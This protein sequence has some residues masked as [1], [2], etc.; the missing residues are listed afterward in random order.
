MLY[1]AFFPPTSDAMTTLFAPKRITIGPLKIRFNWLIAACIGL[2]VFSFIR[3]G[4]WQL[5][6]AEEK[7]QLQQ[8]VEAL[9]S[10]AAVEIEKLDYRALFDSGALNYFN[11]IATGNY[12]NERTVLVVAQF[13]NGQIG[14]EVITPFQLKSN[15]EIILVSRG[16][17][18]AIIPPN[19]PVNTRPVEGEISLSALVHVPKSIPPQREALG[20]QQWPLELRNLNVK[21]IES[22]L[23]EPVF[24]FVVRLNEN[25]PGV[26]ARH[27][28]AV[29]VRTGMNISYAIQWFSF[30]FVVILLSLVF[31]SN[32]VNLLKEKMNSIDESKQ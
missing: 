1:H 21:Q 8:E 25:A 4:N 2:T 11:I 14:Y 3:L 16:W 9:Q 15:A 19:T 31:S 13:F 10:S 12:L 32:I 5:S 26:L 30:A 23:Q 18:T 7:R 28:P 6:R 24:P 17:T 20:D 29:A 27:W 22:F